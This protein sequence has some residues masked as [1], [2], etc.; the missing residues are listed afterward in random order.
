MNING[1]LAIAM[2]LAITASLISTAAKAQTAPIQDQENTQLYRESTIKNPELIRKILI[3]QPG[4]GYEVKPGDFHD[5]HPNLPKFGEAKPGTPFV[6]FKK[7]D[8]GFERINPSYRI[9]PSA[10]DKFRSIGH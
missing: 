4:G 7:P 2:T 9:R 8:P 1:R 10:V 5:A 3:I 6:N